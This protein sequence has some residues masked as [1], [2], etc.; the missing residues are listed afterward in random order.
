MITTVIDSGKNTIRRIDAVWAIV[1]VDPADNTEGMC[2]SLEGGV[3]YPLLAADEDRLPF[4]IREAKKLQAAGRS[5]KL[6]KLTT[7][8]E[9]EIPE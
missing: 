4:I 7:R 6:I 8:E 9:M 1:S 3:W 5:V 2:A